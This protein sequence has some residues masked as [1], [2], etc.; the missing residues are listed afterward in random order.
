M[1]S[2]AQPLDMLD[3]AETLGELADVI[4]VS[5]RR[6]RA[7]LERL[8]SSGRRPL[9]DSRLARDASTELPEVRRGAAPSSH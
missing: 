6:L 8:V 3:I 1:V 7:V 4:E 9:P 2:A 5:D